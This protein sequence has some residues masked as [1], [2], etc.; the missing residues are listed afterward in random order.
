MSAQ[1]RDWEDRRT[2]WGTDHHTCVRDPSAPRRHTRWRP[3]LSSL[4]CFVPDE[5]WLSGCS[6]KPSAALIGQGLT[7]RKPRPSRGLSTARTP[8]TASLPNRSA[9]RR[10]GRSCSSWPAESGR[11]TARVS[12]RRSARRDR[13]V[14]L[15]GQCGA[16]HSGHL[17]PTRPALKLGTRGPCQSLGCNHHAPSAPKPLWRQQTEESQE[18]LGAVWPGPG[19][20]PSASEAAD[21]V[22]PGRAVPVW[23]LSQPRP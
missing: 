14:C 9:A 19:Y 6:P 22:R 2:T 21:G 5:R 16:G 7:I 18:A 1:G 15:E 12:S 20:I 3:A 10:L 8:L 11:V 4:S 17:C 13:D 23:H